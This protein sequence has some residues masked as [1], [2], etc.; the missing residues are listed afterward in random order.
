[1]LIVPG[2]RQLHHRLPHVSPELLYALNPMATSSN[3][4]NAELPLITKVA[5]VVL[6]MYW[7]LAK[8]PDGVPEPVQ[9]APIGVDGLLPPPDGTETRF[10]VASTPPAVKV[11]SW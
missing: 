6:T 8:H 3:P 10:A 11:G 4:L 9:A 5:A 2:R 1:M 7:P